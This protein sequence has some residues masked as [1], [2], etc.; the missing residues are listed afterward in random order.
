MY[1]GSGF[2]WCVYKYSKCTLGQA[3]HDVLI[4][5]PYIICQSWSRCL[6][7][8]L[9][10]MY[11]CLLWSQATILRQNITIFTLM[12]Q[13]LQD[14]CTNIVNVHWV[15]TKILVFSSEIVGWTCLF[16]YKHSVWNVVGITPLVWW[17]RNPGTL[18]SSTNKTGRYNITEIL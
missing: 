8:V 17:G 11:K 14:V 2:T 9:W 15:R 6:C 1:I 16:F 10:I 12:G 7:Y 5:T 13:A 4:L 3:L 18:V